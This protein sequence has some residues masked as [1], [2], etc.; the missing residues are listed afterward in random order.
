MPTGGRRHRGRRGGRRDRGRPAAPQ[1]RREGAG[2]APPVS[3]PAPVPGSS[4]TGPGRQRPSQRHRPRHVKEVYIDGRW[5]QVEGG[6]PVIAP[7]PQRPQRRGPKQGGDDEP[8][9]VRLSVPL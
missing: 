4:R 7:G 5:V 8:P 2:G 1:G 9:G 3:A 6:G